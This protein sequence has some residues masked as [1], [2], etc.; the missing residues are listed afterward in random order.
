MAPPKPATQ[1]TRTKAAIALI[2]MLASPDMPASALDVLD[3]ISEIK[4]MFNRIAR[5]DQWDWF[6]VC[7]Q[8]GYPSLKLSQDVACELGSLRSA[9]KDQDEGAFRKI[10][11]MLTKRPIGLCLAV[12]LGKMKIRQDPGT[13]WIYVLST[14][15]SRTFLK[16]GMTTRTVEQR[17]QEI[18]SATGVVV[19]FGVRRC[20][21]VRNPAEAERIVHRALADF[22]I[23]DD[24]EFFEAEFMRIVTTIQAVIVESG[25]EIRTLNALAP[26]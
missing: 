7:A 20:W 17:V 2:E 24:R 9:I 23:R 10:R 12:F 25:L 21:R 6:T 18:N 26:K 22:R 8:F 15:Q 1:R 19:P 4:G 13:G 14:R 3:A 5:Q 11:E 16:I